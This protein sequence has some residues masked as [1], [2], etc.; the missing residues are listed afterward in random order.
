MASQFR[1]TSFGSVC[2]A[3]SAVRIFAINMATKSV[4]TGKVELQ[5]LEED[6][7][8]EEFETADNNIHPLLLL[9]CAFSA[10][11]LHGY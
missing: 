1:L 3:G 5:E 7:E 6:D 11:V 9:K 2:A 10:F 8:F 4:P